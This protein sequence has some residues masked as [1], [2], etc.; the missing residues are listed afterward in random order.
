MAPLNC[1]GFRRTVSP[2]LQPAVLIDTSRTG[3]RFAL[4]SHTSSRAGSHENVSNDQPIQEIFTLATKGDT[5]HETSTALGNDIASVQETES[6][7]CHRDSNRRLHDVA[8]KVR[9]RMSRDSGI[10]NRS[11]KTSLS[12]D[13]HRRREELKRALHQRVQ[14]DINEGS[15]ISEGSYDEDAVPIKTPKGSFGRH[16]GSIHI[17]PRHLSSALRRP[18]SPSAYAEL[19]PRALSQAYA[20]KNTAAAL[21]RI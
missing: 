16:Q 2:D 8:S 3:G 1:C 15:N 19:D 20:P 18:D 13:N 10:S 7:L 14:E 5:I 21:S 6:G 9:K 12:E 17:S 4:S 11:S